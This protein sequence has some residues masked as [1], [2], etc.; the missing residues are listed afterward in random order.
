[1]KG[2][3]LLLLLPK[4]PLANKELSKNKMDYL[5]SAKSPK[6]DNRKRGSNSRDTTPFTIVDFWPIWRGE[7]VHFIL[8][9][10]LSSKKEFF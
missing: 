10:F 1:M 7:I 2:L 5:T 3:K 4:V 6:I 8:G 9:Q